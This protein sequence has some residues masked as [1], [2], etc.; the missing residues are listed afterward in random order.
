M[1]NITAITREL[2]MSDSQTGEVKVHR[3]WPIIAI[4]VAGGRVV[5]AL[6]FNAEGAEFVPTFVTIQEIYFLNE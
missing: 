5:N 6:S 1:E 4:Q 3:H 2:E